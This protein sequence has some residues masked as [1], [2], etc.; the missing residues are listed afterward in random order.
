MTEPYTSTKWK[1]D[2]C[3]KTVALEGV[4][5]GLPDHKEWTQVTLSTGYGLTGYWG[6]GSRSYQQPERESQRSRLACSLECAQALLASRWR[7][8]W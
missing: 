2:N 5:T 1:C 8:M 3:D 4:H 6:V 7:F